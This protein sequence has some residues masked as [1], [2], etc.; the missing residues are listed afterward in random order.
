LVSGLPWE[1]SLVP[2]EPPQTD[3]PAFWF[4]AEY[5]LWW[6]KKS[7]VPVPLVTTTSQPDLTP[8]AAIGQDGTSVLLGTQALDTGARHGA[9]FTAGSWL[10]VHRTL[11]VEA[12]Y[13]VIASRT[14]TQSVVSNGQANATILA[15]P[16]FD[17]DAGAESS[18]VIAAPSTL[19]GAAVLSL[20]SRLQGAEANGCVRCCSL[21]DCSLDVLAGFRFID[22]RERL[23]FA[24]ASL[25]I[26]PPVPGNNSG[27]VLNSLDQFNTHNEF[28]GFQLGLRGEYRLGSFIL[29]A[30]GKLGMGEVHQVVRTNG[31]V[32]TNFFN[33]PPGGP[34]TGVPTQIIP[35]AGTFVQATNF[36]RTTNNVFGV[37]PELGINVGYQVTDWLRVFVGYDLLYLNNVLRPGNQIDRSIN[38][39][40]TVQSAIAGNAA[41]PG[42]RP[43]ILLNTSEF[44]AQGVNFGVELRY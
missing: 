11:G 12:S 17:A 15:V 3:N 32:V 14:V 23:S 13:F 38:V 26:E 6:F 22:L 19:S 28:Y 42:T 1:P 7:P 40:E 36:G 5:L 33:A 21:I 43:V 16:F 30:T 24:T 20:T 9:R 2:Q 10:D 41:P 31:A 34:F 29:A 18:F 44:W 25:D 37:V 4:S 27:L 39:S 8:T 35:G